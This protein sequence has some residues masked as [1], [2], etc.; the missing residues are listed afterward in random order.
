M[1]GSSDKGLTFVLL[2]IVTC[3]YLS[4]N[5]DDL[6]SA[7]KLAKSAM[8]NSVDPEFVPASVTSLPKEFREAG[9]QIATAATRVASNVRA[10][11][12]DLRTRLAQK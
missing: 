3:L 12:S 4:Y 2:T 5:P 7:R 9:A 1:R 8:S 6:A 10:S 11:V